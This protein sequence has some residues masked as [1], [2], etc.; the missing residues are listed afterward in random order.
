MSKYSNKTSD[1]K[2]YKVKIK[3]CKKLYNKKSNG[4]KSD[5]RTLV[6]KKSDGEKLTRKI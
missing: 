6:A 4:K 1:S 3:K 5:V 2:K